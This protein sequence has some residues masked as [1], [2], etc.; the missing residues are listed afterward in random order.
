MSYTIRPATLEDAQFLSTRLREE[1]LAELKACSGR[2][3]IEALRAGVQDGR[4]WVGCYNGEPYGIFGVAPFPGDPTI[5]NPWMV[6]T[7]DLPKHQRYFIRTCREWV[8]KLHEGYTLL[9]NYV[10]ARNEVHIRWLQ[11]CGF[12]FLNRHEKFGVEQR[13]FFEFVRLSNV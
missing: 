10:D 8:A 1:D 2:T 12:T 6:A 13:P 5:G 4:A 3:P 11:W 9:F 7:A